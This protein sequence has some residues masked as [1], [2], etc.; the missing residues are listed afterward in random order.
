MLQQ[1]MMTHVLTRNVSHI[2]HTKNKIMF[3]VKF[4]SNIQKWFDDLAIT[5]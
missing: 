3:D 1:R 4:A 2:F 5:V